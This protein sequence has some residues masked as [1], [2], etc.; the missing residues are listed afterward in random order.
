MVLFVSSLLLFAGED[1]ILRQ[2]ESEVPVGYLSKNVSKAVRISNP[3][4][5]KKAKTKICRFE[6][7]I[8]RVY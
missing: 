6:K 8:A 4:F 2:F 5:T 1:F 7:S 3:N